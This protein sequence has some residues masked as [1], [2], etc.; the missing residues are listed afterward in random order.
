MLLPFPSTLHYNILILLQSLQLPCL[1][2]A[3]LPVIWITLLHSNTPSLS[4]NSHTLYLFKLL[5]VDQSPLDQF[6]L[7]LPLFQCAFGIIPN[8]FPSTS[9]TL[10]TSLLY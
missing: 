6:V 8:S 10:L 3:P 1:T 4:S 7:K 5:M 2:L 9:F